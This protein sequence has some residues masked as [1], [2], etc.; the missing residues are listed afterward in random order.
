MTDITKLA[1]GRDCLIRV[2]TYCLRT[3]ETV[4]LCHYRMPNLSGFGIKAPDWLGAFGCHA[5]H[6]VVDGQRAS[7]FSPSERDLMLA[8]A[9]FRTQLVLFEE[10]VIRIPGYEPDALPKIFPRRVS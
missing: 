8:E 7:K 9:V 1:N 3:T 4:V 10:G 5:C 2:P 6:Q